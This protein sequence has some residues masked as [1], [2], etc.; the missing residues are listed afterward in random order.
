MEEKDSWREGERK[1][2]EC[3]GCEDEWRLSVRSRDDG[4]VIARPWRRRVC[5]LLLSATELL[6]LWGEES[7]RKC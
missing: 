6:R 4:P 5:V 2:V 1:S 7:V 3:R